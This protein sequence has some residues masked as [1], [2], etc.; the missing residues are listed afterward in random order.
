MLEGLDVDL[1]SAEQVERRDGHV[2]AVMIK[3]KQEKERTI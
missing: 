3:R 1:W 2:V